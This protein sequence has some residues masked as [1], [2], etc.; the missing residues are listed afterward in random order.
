MD[1]VFHADS[2]YVISFD[3]Y[4]TSS[5]K[6]RSNTSQKPTE[7]YPN[8]NVLAPFSSGQPSEVYLLVSFRS[9]IR[10]LPI[11]KKSATGILLF[12]KYC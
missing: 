8:N 6:N 3:W 11:L 1:S 9:S 4:R 10:P 7:N 5:N 12:L 2:K